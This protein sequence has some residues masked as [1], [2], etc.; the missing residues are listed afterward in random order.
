VHFSNSN[1][2]GVL[3]LMHIPPCRFDRSSKVGQYSEIQPLLV[4]WSY[5]ADTLIELFGWIYAFSTLP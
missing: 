2:G 5:Q 4:D 3:I 1:R